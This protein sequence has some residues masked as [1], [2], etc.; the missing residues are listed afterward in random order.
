[1][2]LAA[3]GL[4]DR[5][6]KVSIIKDAIETLNAA[7]GQRTLDE[8]KSLGAQFVS[9]DQALAAAGGKSAR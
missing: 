2:R 3:K 5:G 1:V 7:E 8:L 4:L 6:C 9:T